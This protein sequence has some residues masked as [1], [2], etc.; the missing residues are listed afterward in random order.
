MDFKMTVP[1][2]EGFDSNRLELVGSCADPKNV[3]ATVGVR[4]PVDYT[5]IHGKVTVRKENREGAAALRGFSGQP[6]RKYC[7]V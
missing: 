2:S 6:A 5:V 7:L 4:G 3:L 1:E